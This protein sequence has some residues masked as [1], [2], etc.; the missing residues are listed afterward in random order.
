MATTL[1]KQITLHCRGRQL[2]HVV[3]MNEE[4]PHTVPVKRNRGLH[5]IGLYQTLQTAYV[6][7]GWRDLRTD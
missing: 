3:K 6:A 5:D 2:C 4:Q 1:Q 7:G